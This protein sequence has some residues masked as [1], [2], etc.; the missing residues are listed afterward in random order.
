MT[1]RGSVTVVVCAA[2]LVLMLG[3]LA[4]ADAGAMML[5]RQRA[6]TAA[7]AAALAAVVQ[8]VPALAF[9]DEPA[10]AA[11]AEAERNGAVVVRCDCERGSAVAV[12]EVRIARRGVF[13]PGWIGRHVR[14]VAAAGIDAG[15]LTYRR[16]P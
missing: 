16:G 11:E 7:D 4:L 5:A 6:Q 8:Q 1:A 10:K 15:L 14:A 2:T 13:L 12:V 3:S 9:E